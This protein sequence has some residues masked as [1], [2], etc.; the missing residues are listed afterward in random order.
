MHPR[1]WI[2][3]S[4]LSCNPQSPFHRDSCLI[5]KVAETI[6]LVIGFI[7]FIMALFCLLFPKVDPD[8]TIFLMFVILTATFET[9][10]LSF[11]CIPYLYNKLVSCL[12]PEED[13]LPLV[14][15]SSENNTG[16]DTYRDRPGTD[17]IIV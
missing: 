3:K 5:K 6:F 8:R 4:D 14:D 7:F 13:E 17:R 10:F 12:F 1:I 15:N 9:V 16:Y 11:S 2:Y